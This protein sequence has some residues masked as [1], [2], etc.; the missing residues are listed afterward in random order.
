M[1]DKG[2]D[3]RMSDIRAMMSESVS[4]SVGRRNGMAYIQAVDRSVV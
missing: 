2:G 4:L 3:E 1:S